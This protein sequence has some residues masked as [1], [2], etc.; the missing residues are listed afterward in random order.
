MGAR[1]ASSAAWPAFAFQ[2]VTAST[3]AGR[4]VAGAT[5]VASTSAAMDMTSNVRVGKR[6]TP[7]AGAGREDRPPRPKQL[8][9]S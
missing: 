6:M 9:V 3:L 7:P 5:I 8:N 4:A 2:T 1:H